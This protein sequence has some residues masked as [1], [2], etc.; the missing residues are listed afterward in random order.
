MYLAVASK[1]PHPNL[2]TVGPKLAENM[3]CHIKYAQNPICTL[4]HIYIYGFDM[5]LTKYCSLLFV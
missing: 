5:D 3:V 2:S 1:I 4:L